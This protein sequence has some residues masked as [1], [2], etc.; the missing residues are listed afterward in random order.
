MPELVY[1]TQSEQIELLQSVLI[2][3]ESAADLGSDMVGAQWEADTGAGGARR[4]PQQ[5]IGG[6]TAKATRTTG[7]L[8]AL[9]GANEMSYVERNQSANKRLAKD[10]NTLFKKRAQNSK[11]RNKDG[12]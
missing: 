2:A 12:D 8:G 3:N 10:R 1:K 4:G 6:P 9:S 11:Q 7:S 5:R